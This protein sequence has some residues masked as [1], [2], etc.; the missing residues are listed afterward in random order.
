MDGLIAYALAKKYTDKVKSDIIDAGFK[1][2]VEE[3][4][5]I[6]SRIGKEMTLYFLPKESS[7]YTDNYDEYIYA[8]N[9][10]EWVGS[11]EYVLSERDKEAI[12]QIVLDELPTTEG[13]LY[14]NTS[15]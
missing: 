8:N 11:T 1:V 12:A 2:Q 14:G 3:D 5:S 4:R 13:V 7:I 10:W 15:N 6:L 9:R